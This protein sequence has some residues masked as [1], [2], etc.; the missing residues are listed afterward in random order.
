MRIRHV[1]TDEIG[2]SC[3]FKSVTKLIVFAPEYFKCVFALMKVAVWGTFQKNRN[4]IRVQIVENVSRIHSMTTPSLGSWIANGRARSQ[5]S[6]FGRIRQP[7]FE[8]R[9]TLTHK[10][11]LAFVFGL[12]AI[13]G[14]AAAP[15]HATE[16]IDFS[17]GLAG[18]GGTIAYAG[19]SAPLVGTGIYIGA[20]SG[21][22]TPLNSG[23]GTTVTGT[24][25]GNGSLD[26]TTGAYQSYSSGTYTFGSGGTFTITG[27]VAAAGINSV[28]NLLTG[29]FTSAT[30]TQA[31]SPGGLSVATFSGVDTKNPDLLA[32]FGIPAGTSF[33]F[34]NGFSI[35]FSLLGGGGLAF[36][37]IAFSTDIPNTVPVP[38]PASLLL[39]GSGL[40]ALGAYIRRRNGKQHAKET[41]TTL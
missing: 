16:I 30:V 8:G 31:T 6:G 18:P 14:L 32:Y 27:A 22:N 29:T 21:V 12:L 33:T 11:R 7:D 3:Q 4:A 20:V 1:T 39:L 23:P 41:A 35:A 13:L 36:S 38:E 17:T 2:L 9:T 10:S 25:G 37:D 28:T 24:A 26:F 15:A 34:S 5:R 19:G 40:T